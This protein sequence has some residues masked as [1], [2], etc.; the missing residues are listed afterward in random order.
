M[1]VL[2]CPALPWATDTSTSTAAMSTAI[3][4][5]CDFGTAKFAAAMAMIAAY[6][7][8]GEEEEQVWEDGEKKQKERNRHTIYTEA[9]LAFS[10]PG[11]TQKGGGG[12]G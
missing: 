3:W 6:Q 1:S 7:G 2:V 11:D 10:A 8:E 5:V 12:R 4:Y 9:V